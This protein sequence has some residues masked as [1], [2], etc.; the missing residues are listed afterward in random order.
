MIP[1]TAA[2]ATQQAAGWAARRATRPGGPSAP[3]R[4]LSSDSAIPMANRSRN[5][6]SH[7]S[8]CRAH[9]G[10]ITTTRTR[11]AVPVAH[12]AAVPATSTPGRVAAPPGRQPASRAMPAAYSGRSR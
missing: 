8:D 12:S 6:G 4:A 5:I 9:E 11:N 2:A 3:Y 1:S 7:S 10:S